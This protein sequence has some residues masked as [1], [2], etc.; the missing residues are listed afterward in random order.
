MF[1]SLVRH[2]AALLDVVS[3]Q[4]AHD[5][6]FR[7][8]RPSLFPLGVVLIFIVRGPVFR[9]IFVIIIVVLI[10]FFFRTSPIWEDLY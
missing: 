6:T 1:A 3:A 7:V 10:V 2:H 4:V 5:A 8:A 9:V